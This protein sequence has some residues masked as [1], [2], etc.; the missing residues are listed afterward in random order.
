MRPAPAMGVVHT[1]AAG[2]CTKNGVAQDERYALES[3]IRNGTD[4]L[5]RRA[6]RGVP[7][8]VEFGK[9]PNASQYVATSWIGEIP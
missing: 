5:R 3:G 1:E 8:G 2:I 6:A 7:F 4:S 9:A